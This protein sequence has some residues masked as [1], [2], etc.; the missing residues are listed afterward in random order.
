ML[1]V[2]SPQWQWGGKGGAGPG[3]VGRGGVRW[4]G[5]RWSGL[6]WGGRLSG[7]PQEPRA[8]STEL[9]VCLWHY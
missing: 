4:D 2:I 3:G 1:T 7:R 9:L 5:L 6:G 8:D